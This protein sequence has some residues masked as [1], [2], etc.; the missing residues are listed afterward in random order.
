MPAAGPVGT[1]AAGPDGMDGDNVGVWAG[2]LTS[3]VLLTG[4]SAAG[5]LDGAL[6]HA[7][8]SGRPIRSLLNEPLPPLMLYEPRAEGT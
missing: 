2:R 4:A 7:E 5:R 6:P 1:A 3:G 8:V